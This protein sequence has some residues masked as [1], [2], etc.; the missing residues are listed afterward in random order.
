MELHKRHPNLNG[1][2]ALACIGAIC[3]HRQPVSSGKAEKAV[4]GVAYA[5]LRQIVPSRE[6]LFAKAEAYVGTRRC[7][8]PITI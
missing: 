1:S 2:V 7:F 6:S 8:L 5:P 4:I 3:P